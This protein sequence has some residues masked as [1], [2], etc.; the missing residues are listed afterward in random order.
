MRNDKTLQL[1]RQIA[2]INAVVPGIVAQRMVRMARAGAA[3]SRADRA[4]MTR[5]SS[6]KW[7]AATQSMFAATRFT[8]DLQMRTMQMVWQMAMAPWLGTPA[9]RDD[10]HADPVGDPV[11]GLMHAALAP[12][13]RIATA[14]A[15]RLRGR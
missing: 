15:R 6:E 2:E 7:D 14:N 8:L 1:G 10:G 13:H 11:A 5:M 9:A 12:Y 4:E 3:P